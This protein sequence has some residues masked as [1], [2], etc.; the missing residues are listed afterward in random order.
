MKTGTVAI[1]GAGISGFT[2]ATAFA[3]RG[4]EV[5]VYERSDKPREFG[6]GIYL[7]DNSLPVLDALG[8]GERIASA[9]TRLRT[10]QIV[11]ERQQVIVTR[12]VSR[13]RLI[14][15]LRSDLH[16][17][18]REAAHEAGVN[19]VTNRTATSATPDGTLKFADGGEMHAD[20]VIGADGVRSQ[21]RES[22]GLTR[23]YRKLQ[24]GATRLLV[25]RLEDARSV[26]YWAGNRRIGI[27]P[28]TPSLSYVFMIGPENSP[29]CGAVPIDQDYWSEAFPHLSHLFERITGQGVHHQHEE[30]VCSRWAAGRL[31]L[32]GDAAHAQPPNLGQG[33]G[34]AISAA[35]ELART[36]T[37]PADVPAQLV[38]WERRVRPGIDRVQKLTT[39]YGHAGYYWP[40]FALRARARLFH[41]LSVVPPTAHSWEFWWRGGTEAPAPIVPGSAGTDRT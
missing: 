4:F 22:L 11:D 10:A 21:V 35:W 34:L 26:E 41:A 18:L 7:K 31:A 16:T 2:A 27:A 17:A 5:T 20:L 23:S 15:V 33:A 9:G 39:L 29:R 25:P 12:D 37:E 19:L 30:V 3:Q 28:C 32:V 38:D 1:A 6:A 24:D 36:V 40:P 13:E 8:V 14:V